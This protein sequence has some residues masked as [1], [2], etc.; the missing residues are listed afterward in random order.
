MMT[1]PPS[2]VLFDGEESTLPSTNRAGGGGDDDDDD[3]QLLRSPYL[4]P[5]H[6]SSGGG[7]RRRL[8]SAAADGAA[9]LNGLNLLNVVTYAAHLFVSWGIGVRGLGGALPTRWQLTARY[10]TLVTPAEWAYYLWA[11]ILILEGV[12]TVAQL[13]P[14]YRARPIIQAGTRFFF[15][16]TF[17]IQT[18]WTLFFSFGLFPLSFIAAVG[19]LASLLALLESQNQH[20]STQSGRGLGSG[21]VEYLLFRFPFYMHAGWMVLMTVDHFSLLFR[22]Y[23]AD[24]GLQLSIDIVSLGVML[25]V[26]TFYLSRSS[27]TDF[28]I[29][30]VIAWS[31][32]GITCRLCHPSEIMVELY[33]PVVIEAVR[34]ATLFFVG[35]VGCW[36]APNVVVWFAREFCTINVV[37][38]DE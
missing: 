21:L 38:L 29:P 37:E 3:E 23:S 35:I 6:S 1:D 2:R 10:E 20:C 22:R 32:I 5:P 16:Y 8:Y 27:W 28:V 26:A 14:Y 18:A 19:A 13:F 7:R 12:F 36:L 33:G 9:E 31:Y 24:T 15:F 30:V 4:A 25:Q 34:L 17:L 11:P